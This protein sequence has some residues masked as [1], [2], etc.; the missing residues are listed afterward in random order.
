M[1]ELGQRIVKIPVSSRL[2]PVD[3][4]Q[5]Q[6]IAAYTSTP[7]DARR[8]VDSAQGP[9]SFKQLDGLAHTFVLMYK[10]VHLRLFFQR[11]MLQEILDEGIPTPPIAVQNP[12]QEWLSWNLV[13]D[14]DKQVIVQDIQGSVTQANQER[15]L[16]YRHLAEARQRFEKEKAEYADE[17]FKWKALAAL[18]EKKI[19][20]QEKQ[21]NSHNSELKSLHGRMGNQ[22][23]KA[24]FEGVDSAVKAL[25]RSLTILDKGI[26]TYA[27]PETDYVTVAFRDAVKQITDLGCEV[28]IPEAGQVFDPN[29]HNA[30]EVL[31]MDEAELNGKIVERHSIGAR[32]GQ[33]IIQAAEVVV[34]K[35]KS[36]T[37]GVV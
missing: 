14:A 5:A 4:E 25:L 3:R 21:I 37:T 6:A 27:L 24:K 17:L 9:W 18:A 7:E 33:V 15:D 20:E 19:D 12:R 10:G 34:A 32:H 23:V 8:L 35:V 31:E 22:V 11:Q 28:I 16:V 2:N 30:V 36:Q 29:V 1:I 13:D 26:T